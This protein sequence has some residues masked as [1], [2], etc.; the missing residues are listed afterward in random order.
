M[1]L[2][3]L[4]LQRLI[5]DALH[6]DP[7][8]GRR[9]A[10]LAG[11]SLVLEMREPALKIAL[12]IEADGAE[13]TTETQTAHID[14]AFTEPELV[15]ARVSGRA[16]DLLAVLRSTDR[17][18]AMMAHQIDIQGDTRTFFTLQ[19]ILAELEIDWEMA[20]GDR[21]GDLPAHWLAEGLRSFA[22]WARVQGESTERT[23]N[24]YLREESDALVPN[25]LWQAHS[26]QVHNTRLAADR[27]AARLERLSKRL[28][29][30]TSRS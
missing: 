24:N 18:Q 30:E 29:T 7:N 27:L 1:S 13:D 20:L 3:A 8:A 16:T 10:D 25:S 11:Q 22:G 15:N 19:S 28:D 5:N 17:T 2:L 21:L 23:L 12:S 26:E 4:P 9:L 14:V 6:Y